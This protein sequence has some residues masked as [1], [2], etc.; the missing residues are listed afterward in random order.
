MIGARVVSRFR[1]IEAVI[2]GGICVLGV[3]FL[4]APRASANAA[5]ITWGI[6]LLCAAMFELR[7]RGH[8]RACVRAQ[9]TLGE[10]ARA[11]LQSPTLVSERPGDELV[12][13]LASN[14][15]LA[16]LLA[17][18]STRFFVSGERNARSFEIGTA[19]VA[20]RDFDR[21]HS[22]VCLRDD[23]LP[24]ALRVM[25]RGAVTSFARMGMSYAHDVKT[26]DATFDAVWIVDADEDVVRAVLDDGMRK[27][28]L[29]LQS[30]LGWMQVASL[31]ATRFGLVVRWP[32]T[33]ETGSA[34]YLCDL[35]LAM[36]ARF[37]AA[38]S[39]AQA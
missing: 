37:V 19:V 14:P 6:A 26:G 15:Q 39:V 17:S 20:L 28:L 38:R 32:S 30:R 33:I 13:E 21:H 9:K 22:Y 5:F 18:R 4:V 34:A 8:R 10:I 12:E 36:H 29:D 27:T 16:N 24:S 25:T 7:V 2:C 11:D 35:V 1:T 3:L 23:R 31:E